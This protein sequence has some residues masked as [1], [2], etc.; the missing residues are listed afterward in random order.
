ML[1]EFVSH[2]HLHFPCVNKLAVEH[3]HTCSLLPSDHELRNLGKIAY[4]ELDSLIP[5]FLHEV[6]KI[7]RPITTAKTGCFPFIFG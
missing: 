1:W 2:V 5:G 7:M 6:F 3:F 4:D